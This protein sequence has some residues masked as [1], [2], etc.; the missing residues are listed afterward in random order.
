MRAYN[1]A[2]G[3]AMLPEEVLNQINKELFNWKNTGVSVM[4]I[5]HRTKIFQNLLEN[6][7]IKLKILMQIP[8]NYKIL[9]LQGGAQGQFA[10]IPMNLVKYNKDVDYFVT[11]IWSKRAADYAKAYANVNIVTEVTVNGG[12]PDKH[13]W[14]LNSKAA[15]AY[16]CPNET[17]N[18]VQFDSIPDVGDV[19]LIADMTSSILSEPFDISKFGLVFASAQ[20][21]LGIAGVTLVIVR[22]DLLNN[23]LDILPNIWNYKLLS[24]CNSS[25]N[26]VPV[27]AIYVMDLMI[28]WVIKQ[29]GV[30]EIAKVNKRKASKLYNYIDSSNFYSNSVDKTYRSQV[31]IPFSLQSSEL[32][33]IFLDMAV[34]NN[35]KYLQGHA[36]V[37]G[38]RASLYNA[39]PEDGVD[40]LIEFMDNFAILKKI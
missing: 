7:Q 39:M 15:Y 11:G 1:F 30:E 29:G 36:L 5:G 4:E 38:A 8:D 37:G 34:Q 22:D 23:N 13:E 21:N 14:N 28:D 24:A 3:P 33:E 6:L 27:F 19:P 26:T 25:V 17:I 10:A 35:L 16:Y 2:A 12:I 31:N 32:L 18:G 9:F 20:K 40:K